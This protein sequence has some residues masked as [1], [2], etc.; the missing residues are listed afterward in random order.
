MNIYVGNLAHAATE[1][2]VRDLFSQ[3]GEVKSVKI[4]KDRF[5]GQSR[6]FAFVEMMEAENGAKALEDLNGQEFI[7]RRLRI[8]E[9][10][11]REN[12][13][14]GGGFNRG[15]NRGG[16]QRDHGGRF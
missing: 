12:R 13:P 4:I 9:A 1:D 15:G 14:G 8:S 2:Q 11:K 10:N 7:G 5:T 6:G 16:F 3:F